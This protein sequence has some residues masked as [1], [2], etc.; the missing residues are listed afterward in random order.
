MSFPGA[1]SGQPGTYLASKL[2][3]PN[4]VSSLSPQAVFG[5]GHGLSYAPAAWEEIGLLSPER[6]P[7]NGICEVAVTLSNPADR[8]TSEV[9]QVY[10]H[11]PVAEVVRPVQQLVAF[12]RVELAP[13]ARRRVRIRLHA[14]LTSFTGRAPERIVEP[15]EVSLRVG[16]SSADIRSV[17]RLRLTG[18]RRVVGYD[19]RRSPE[20]AIESA[21]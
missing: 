3:A 1:G 15:G 4:D 16:A 10:L 17:L 14:D 20:I 7:T 13:G 9:V 5:F 19:R 11:D 21:P 2:A 8:A 12:S 6:W 18:P